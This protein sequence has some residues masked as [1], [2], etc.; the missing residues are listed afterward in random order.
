MI[1]TLLA[2]V[3]IAAMLA[4]VGTATAGIGNGKGVD[5][6]NKN[7]WEDSVGAMRATCPTA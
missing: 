5:K 4:S 2:S 6:G 1:R 3:A 7:G